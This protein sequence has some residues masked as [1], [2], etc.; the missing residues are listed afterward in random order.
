MSDDSTGGAPC[1]LGEAEWRKSTFSG[2]GECLIVA[3]IGAEIAV[4]NSNDPRATT[5]FFARRGLATL[6]AGTKAGEFDDLSG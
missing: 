6:I 2:A 1:G 5:L 3:E 4:R